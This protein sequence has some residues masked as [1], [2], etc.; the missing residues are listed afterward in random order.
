M[1]FVTVGTTHY[2][3]DRLA[4][5]VN[6]CASNNPKEIITI[7]SGHTTSF[8]GSTNIIS[9]RFYTFYKMSDLIKT[10]RIVVVQAG[11]GSVYQALNLSKNP[12]IIVARDPQYGEHVDNQ[13]FEI[14]EALKKEK[15]AVVLQNPKEL[16]TAIKNYDKLS[17]NIKRRKPKRNRQN[18]IV[19]FL[20]DYTNSYFL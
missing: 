20:R 7:Q 4:D 18:K 9:K 6:H 13:Q 2:P 11:E 5:A 1:I 10:A 17:K 12:P 8:K 14:A 15:C 16:A 3:F 19:K